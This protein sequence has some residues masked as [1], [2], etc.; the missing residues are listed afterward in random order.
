MKNK[1]SYE[2]FD[3]YFNFLNKVFDF[4]QKRNNRGG[5][6]KKNVLEIV[7]NLLHI[8][9]QKNLF[10]LLIFIDKAFNYRQGKLIENILEC[11]YTFYNVTDKKLSFEYYEKTKKIL[12]KY[13]KYGYEYKLINSFFYEMGVDCE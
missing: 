9:K 12:N 1:I 10:K 7:E 3:L 5:N 13:S 2:I 8:S 4:K 6:R 11:L